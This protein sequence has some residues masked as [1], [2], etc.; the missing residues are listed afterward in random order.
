M[1]RWIDWHYQTYYLP[2]FAVDKKNQ[3]PVFSVDTV[4]MLAVDSTSN[5]G[6]YCFGAFGL[7]W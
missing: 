5:V 7:H 4:S 1:D 3:Q 2:C 6:K